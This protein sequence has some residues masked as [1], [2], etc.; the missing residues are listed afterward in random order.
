[1]KLWQGIVIAVVS[2]VLQACLLTAINYLL[3]RH[4]AKQNEELLKRAKLQGPSPAHHHSPAAQEMTKPWAERGT[5]VLEPRYR[6][7]IDTSTDST[8]TS[9]NASSSSPTSQA[10]K[11]VNYT[12]V[13]FSA[14]GGLKNESS[15]DYEDIKEA[16]DYV[17]INPKSHKH[18]F[19]AFVNPA[20]SEP[21]EYTQ[22]DI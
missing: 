11:D 16:T 3:S 2:L 19:W 21:G 4:M 15:L 5:P 13:V 6:H 18:D 1:M 7:G 14:T 20:V 12:Q 10:T 9:D 17:N 22:V 8:N